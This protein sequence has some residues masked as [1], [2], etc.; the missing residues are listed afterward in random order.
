VK[1]PKLLSSLVLTGI[2]CTRVTYM[3]I[4]I[5]STALAT[6]L[7]CDHQLQGVRGYLDLYK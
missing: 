3:S 1:L 2:A 7:Y 5:Y 6:L 4:I